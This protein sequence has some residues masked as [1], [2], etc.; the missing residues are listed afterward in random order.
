[1]PNESDRPPTLTLDL[2]EQLSGMLLLL[3]AHSPTGPGC[4]SGRSRS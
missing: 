2:L 3:S 4:S 1:M